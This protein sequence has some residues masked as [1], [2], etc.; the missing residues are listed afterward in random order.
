MI[1]G[2]WSYP[3]F[4]SLEE[5]TRL[6]PLFVRK[7]AAKE[8]RGCHFELLNIVRKQTGMNSFRVAAG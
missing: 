6:V 7:N 3:N 2:G 4:R 5:K 1:A 8:S